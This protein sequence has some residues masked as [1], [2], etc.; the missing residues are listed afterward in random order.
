MSLKT[1]LSNGSVSLF[2]IRLQWYISRKP[3]PTGP[4]SGLGECRRPYCLHFGPGPNWR[5]PNAHWVNV[6]VNPEWGDIVVDF[7]DFSGIPLEKASVRCI[8]G[9]H[10]F[11]HVNPWVA[12]DLFAECARVIETGG[13]MRIV[14]PDVQRSIKAYLNEESD[15]PLFERRRRRAKEMYGIDY[16]LFDCLLEDFVSRSGQRDLLGKNPL[17]HQNAW[18][19]DRISRDLQRA[20]FSRVERSDFRQSSIPEFSFEGTYP[21]EANEYDRSLYV[22]A[23]K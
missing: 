11:E 14:L 23:V 18:D 2:G 20:G 21:A 19:F 4:D 10:V 12:D 7:T 1:F 9:S 15:F 16:T 13:V 17:A 5:K 8:Y 22:E 6:D 3:R